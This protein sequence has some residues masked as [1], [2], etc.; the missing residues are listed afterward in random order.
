MCVSGGFCGQKP[1]TAEHCFGPP[2]AGR[3]WL[4]LLGLLADCS[5]CRAAAPVSCTRGDRTT[6]H[7][8]QD[9]RHICHTLL[10]NSPPPEHIRAGRQHIRAGRRPRLA[11]VNELESSHVSTARLG[12]RPTSASEEDS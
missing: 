4:R 7:P 3:A 9:L 8:Q 11:L 1:A 10:P 6:T 5:C 12:P 2:R